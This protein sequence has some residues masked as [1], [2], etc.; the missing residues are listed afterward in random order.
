MCSDPAQLLTYS[1]TAQRLKMAIN[2]GLAA[3]LAIPFGHAQMHIDYKKRTVLMLHNLLLDVRLFAFLLFT[4]LISASQAA[5]INIEK[6]RQDVFG[7]WVVHVVGEARTRTLN[8]KGAEKGRSGGWDLD[9]T[10]GWSDGNHTAVKAELI[11]KPDGYSLQITTQANSRIVVDH[12]GAES[13]KGNF[14]WSSGK[15]SEARLQR[16]SSEEISKRAA[17]ETGAIKAA[18]TP[19]GPDVPASCAS[20]FGGWAGNW[21]IHGGQQ[22]LWIVSIDATCMAK[23]QIGRSGYRGPY[24]TAQIKNGVL[25]TAGAEGGTISWERQ[26]DDLRAFYRGSAGTTTAV[27]KKIQPEAK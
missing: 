13:F 21:G 3:L 9:A 23:Y 17:K 6:I 25:T 2:S 11:G 7:S 26:G 19:P 5:D 16:L 24:D 14:R 1:A 22:W 27:H 4:L 15:T 8:I 18:M 12:D 20:M 10:Y